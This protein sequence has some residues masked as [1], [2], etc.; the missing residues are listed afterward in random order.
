MAYIELLEIEESAGAHQIAE[1]LKD[2][3]KYFTTL[4]STAPTVQLKAIYQKKLS[5]LQALAS[6]YQVDLSASSGS[7]K[8]QMAEQTPSSELASRAAQP[9]ALLVLHTE[10]RPLQSFPLLIGVNILGRSQGTSGHTILID[11]DYMSRAHAVVEIISIKERSALLYDIGEL[12]GN[13]P[14]TN[15]VYLNGHETRLTG[16]VSLSHND[17]LQVGYA[18]LVLTYAAATEQRDTV[19]AIGKKEHSKTVFIKVN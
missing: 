1:R 6:K 11:D 15:G 4:A 13:K 7:V 14:S 19:T 10:G 17:T 5:D 16:K 18:K 9:Q 8:P 3:H 2:R 12:P